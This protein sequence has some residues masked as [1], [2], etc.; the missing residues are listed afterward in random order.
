MDKTEGRSTKV[1][2]GVA[3]LYM[4]DTSTYGFCIVVCIYLW[5]MRVS[6]IDKHQRYNR[7]FKKERLI[8]L[9]PQYCGDVWCSA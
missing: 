6:L 2:N 5:M 8:L 7:A 4:G 1:I 9:L 3:E